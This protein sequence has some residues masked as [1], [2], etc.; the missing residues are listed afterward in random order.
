MKKSEFDNILKE[1]RNQLSK[2]L[3]L[4][5]LI[6]RQDLPILPVDE[7]SADSTLDEKYRCAFIIYYIEGKL[8]DFVITI[9]D[10]PLYEL[11]LQEDQEK[12]AARWNKTI[13]E[14]CQK[15]QS[16]KYKRWANKIEEWFDDENI[17]IEEV[18]SLVDGFSDSNK[19]IGEWPDTKISLVL[20]LRNDKD[21]GVYKTYAEAYRWAEEHITV[22]GGEA[23]S[24]ER[25]AGLYYKSKSV[26]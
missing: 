24:A 12:V 5:D 25:L 13:L 17:D 22:N 18:V 4:K 19:F 3:V 9:E 1:F 20:D 11:C 15:K 14:Y 21:N 6:N 2:Y 8:E 26:N 23:V 7:V 16:I 10:A